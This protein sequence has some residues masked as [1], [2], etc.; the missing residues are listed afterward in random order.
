MSRAEPAA[1][2]A[3]E[4]FAALADPMRLS[5]VMRLSDGGS[6]SIASLSV[7]ARVSRQAVSKHLKVLERARLVASA[8][9]GR[10]S[11]YALR[12]EGLDP[13]RHWIEAVGA[14]WEDALGR[15][16]AFVEG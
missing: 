1:A 10:E 3:A 13:A 14:Q 16:K 2:A 15:L 6:R 8:R 4:V 12:P 11:R 7:D 5:L 9:A